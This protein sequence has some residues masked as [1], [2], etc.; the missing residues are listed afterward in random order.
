MTSL[1]HLRQLN[2]KQRFERQDWEQQPNDPRR[3][4]V[5][6]GESFIQPYVATKVLLEFGRR[7]RQAP[8][9]SPTAGPVRSE[10]GELSE[11]EVD[12][13]RL[14]TQGASNREIA[15]RLV[16]AEGT[17]KNH[18]SSILMKLYAAN[19]THA[20]NLARERGLI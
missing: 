4:R 14:L 19:R 11:R 7:S 5:H 15:D 10:A 8:S 18:V 17:V 16:L 13:L 2:E 20:A 1:V 9:G 12:V 6:A 3:S